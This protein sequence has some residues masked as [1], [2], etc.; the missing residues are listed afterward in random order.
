MRK[1]AEERNRLRGR[2]GGGALFSARVRT[3][4]RARVCARIPP[5]EVGGHRLTLRRSVGRFQLCRVAPFKHS[6]TYRL[7]C[8]RAPRRDRLAIAS[9][10]SSEL[11]RWRI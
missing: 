8:D 10:A 2:E 7:T 11:A 5:P 6:I 4:R 9:R 1:R 3:T